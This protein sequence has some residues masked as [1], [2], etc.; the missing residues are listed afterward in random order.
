M[1]YLHQQVDVS[2]LRP[3]PW[4][5]NIVSPDN[6][7][8]LDESLK[9]FGVFKP[10]LVRETASGLEILGGQHRWEAA[11]RL[12]HKQVPVINLGKIDESTA[13]EVGLVDNG[14]YGV[15]DADQL[16][17]LL[18]DLGKA[19]EL[20]S[21]LPYSDKELDVIFK[22]EALDFD[23]LDIDGDDEIELK[24]TEISVG[25][26]HQIMRFKVPVEDAEWI[27]SLIQKVV[28][29]QGLSES[30]SLT[31]AGDALVHILKNWSA[32]E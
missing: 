10:I 11:K 12:G 4:N 17:S 2:A 21:F 1:Q 3:N 5:T 27:S 29:T 16:A 6:E 26:S 25:P 28:K 23:A 8:K 18:K 14:R 19:S 24:P 9:R 30:D 13:K 20:A 31:N 32:D 15:D 22:T 7:A